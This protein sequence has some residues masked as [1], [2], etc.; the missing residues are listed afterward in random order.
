ATQ[1]FSISQD[2]WKRLLA[3]FSSATPLPCEHS[4][5]AESEEGDCHRTLELWLT[6]ELTASLRNLADT[7]QVTLNTLLQGAWALL[8]GFYAGTEDVVFGATRACRGSSV[9]GT[10]SM[11]GLLI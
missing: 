1:D 9:E 3:G 6:E 10:E 11:V 8:L 5:Q 4:S 2:Y 7:C